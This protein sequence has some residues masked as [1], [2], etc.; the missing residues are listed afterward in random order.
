[1]TTDLVILDP[2]FGDQAPDEPRPGAEM[3]SVVGVAPAAAGDQAGAGGGRVPLGTRRALFAC[4]PI[5][6]FAQQIGMAQVPGVL[7]DQV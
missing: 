1:V 7:L 6:A 4:Y 3:I 5:E 2:A